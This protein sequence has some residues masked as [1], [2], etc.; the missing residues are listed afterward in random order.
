MKLGTKYWRSS[1]VVVGIVVAL[2][3]TTVAFAG[4]PNPRVLP[5]HSHPRG[6]TYGEWSARW[7]QYA[8]TVPGMA[9]QDVFNHC[10]GQPSGKVWFLAGTARGST[11]TRSC[12]VP[13]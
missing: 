10:P 1:L 7:W 6:L 13:S 9:G 8:V 5:P 3:G 12:T 4:N 11:V 2:I